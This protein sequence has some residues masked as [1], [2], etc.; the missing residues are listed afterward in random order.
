MKCLTS[1]NIS[2]PN[3]KRKILTNNLFSYNHKKNKSKFTF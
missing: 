1:E 3:I 2:N